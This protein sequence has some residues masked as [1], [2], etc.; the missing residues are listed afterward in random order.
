MG[1]LGLP[2]AFFFTRFLVKAAGIFS[3]FLISSFLVITIVSSH[4]C[5]SRYLGSSVIV[6]K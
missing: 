1:R 4:S 3:T 5:V 2:L 6:A